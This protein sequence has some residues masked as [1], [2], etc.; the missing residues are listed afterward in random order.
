MERN[1]EAALIFEQA[2]AL[3]QQGRAAE[4]QQGYREV[5]RRRPGDAPALKMLGILALQVN[6]P[7][8][9]IQYFSES[10]RYRTTAPAV[11]W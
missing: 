7:E 6:Q 9:V 10:F 2:L 3:H 5:L 1:P 11:R 4:A 8:Q